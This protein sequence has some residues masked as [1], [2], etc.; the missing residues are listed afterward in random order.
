MVVREELKGALSVLVESWDRALLWGEGECVIEVDVVEAGFGGIF[1]TKSIVDAIDAC[2]VDCAEAHRAGLAGGV[3]FAASE[4]EVAELVA[5]VADGG[6][7]AVGGGVVI[8]EDLVPAFADD[9]AIAD[10]DRT[11]WAA[12]TGEHA[13]FR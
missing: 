13:A 10:D 2:P 7:F 1:N 8:A 12:V 6:D 11:E 9:F 5:G 4:F 3:D